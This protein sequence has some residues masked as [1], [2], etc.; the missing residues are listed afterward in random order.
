MLACP[1]NHIVF[2]LSS[3]VLLLI[4]MINSMAVFLSLLKISLIMWE[5]TLHI[6]FLPL[7]MRNIIHPMPLIIEFL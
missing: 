2:K 7:P 4:P 5:E 3:I 1:M 6:H